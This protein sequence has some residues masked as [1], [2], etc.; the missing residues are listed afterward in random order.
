MMIPSEACILPPTDDDVKPFRRT[1]FTSALEG[2]W[3][4]VGHRE[5]V[6]CHQ[7]RWRVARAALELGA[8]LETAGRSEI[9]DNWLRDG[10]TLP[11]TPQPVPGSLELADG[12]AYEVLPQA[13]DLMLKD[14]HGDARTYLLPYPQHAEKVVLYVSGGSVHGIAPYHRSPLRVS[15]YACHRRVAGSSSVIC[16]PLKPTMLKLV[17]NPLPGKPFPVPQRGADESEGVVLFEADIAAHERH[18]EDQWIGITI[19]GAD[20]HGWVVAGFAQAKIVYDI[21]P[22]GKYLLSSC[23]IRMRAKGDVDVAAALWRHR[24]ELPREVQLR[25]QID[26]PNLVSNVLAV[27]KLTA[28][29]KPQDESPSCSGIVRHYNVYIC[30]PDVVFR[31]TFAAC[32]HAYFAFR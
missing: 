1:V 29:F 20:G 16:S 4:G 30:A 10:H 14:P 23:F 25:T 17:P 18:D 21:W 6:W 19:D 15:P 31:Y 11:P 26:F 28:K 12:D 24:V 9:L 22:G 5:M 13:T 32:C 27:Y 8:M 7:V 3:T 2:A